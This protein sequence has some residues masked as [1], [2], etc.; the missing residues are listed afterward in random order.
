MTI[1]ATSNPE[2][3]WGDVFDVIDR[4][5]VDV[6]GETVAGAGAVSGTGVSVV[7]SGDAA[8]KKTVLTFT[9]VSVT[10]T[11]A[12]TAG[13]HG[14]LKV[15]DFPA[16]LLSYLGGTTDLTIARVGTTI[17]TTAAVVG[18][19]GTTA[20]ATDDDAL[21]TTEADLIPSTASTLTA[22]AGVT[23][24][25]YAVAPQVPFD[26]TTEAIDA[27]LNFAIPDA[28]S[29]GN[30]ALLVNGTVTLVWSN[31]GDN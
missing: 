10:M 7:E 30:G 22:G 26:G 20:T 29:T 11:D 6:N 16:G 21:T 27:Y 5:I 24:G 28:G 31:L 1:V 18:A 8:L 4:V 2:R 14:S 3:S 12:T 19:V 25:K 13:S 23:K 9:N 17:T 15:Y